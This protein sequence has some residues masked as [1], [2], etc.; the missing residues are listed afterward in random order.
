VVV[1]E[2]G[3]LLLKYTHSVLKDLED[4]EQQI[5]NP[6]EQLAGHLRIGAYATLA[7]YLW[8]KLL[9]ELRKAAVHL[10]ISIRTR[11]L[12]SHQQ[13]LD[14]GEI[15]M[16]IDAEPRISGSFVSWK[17]YEDRFNFYLPRVTSG[18]LSPDS[19]KLLPLIYCPSAFDSENKTILQHLEE[20]GYQFSEKIELDSF[21]TVLAF[22]KAGLGLGVLPQRLVEYPLKAKALHTTCLRGFSTTGFGSHH[23]T[24]TI[25][26]ERKDD[27]RIRFVIRFLKKWFG[28]GH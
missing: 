4:F 1:T 12:V 21:S 27:P 22:T 16:L 14:R 17:L 26:E 2:A 24:A 11:E 20:R 9:P 7:E 23:F 19:A 18:S 13:A 6:S 15:D 25:K 10:K 5:K 28:Q 3:R 8:P